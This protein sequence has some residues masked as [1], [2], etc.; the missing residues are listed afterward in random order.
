MC[1]AWNHPSWCRCGFGGEGA[2]GGGGGNY[3][4]SSLFDY[5]NARRW[6]T[7]DFCVRRQCP[8]CS[9]NPV[10]LIHHNGG[11]VWVEI[12]GPPWTKHPCFDV[13]TQTNDPFQLLLFDPPSETPLLGI[14]VQATRDP[15]NPRIHF[16]VRCENREIA[17][18]E[19]N[20]TGNEDNLEGSLI[21]LYRKCRQ[22]RLAPLGTLHATR[23]QF[24]SELSSEKVQSS[25]VESA[26][27]I[28]EFHAS[29]TTESPPAPEN[30]RPPKRFGL[31]WTDEELKQW[32]QIIVR[33]VADAT[34]HIKELAAANVEAK[35]LAMEKIDRLP[36]PLCKLLR[37]LFELAKWR[38]VL[39]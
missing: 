15:S 26:K 9:K 34:S 37:H 7:D 39:R 5:A 24:A 16:E 17:F 28:G 27:E 10:W 30:D 12:L 2:R 6:R 19:C 33:E 32:E 36:R 31:N 23:M 3:S 13:A 29:G 11:S 22:V 14:V 25:V 4:H 35:H 21:F 8:K 38:Q 18:I 1:N 20:F